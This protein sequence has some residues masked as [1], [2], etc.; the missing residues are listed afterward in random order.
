[1]IPVAPV[2]EPSLWNLKGEEK[3]RAWLAQRPS[4]DRPR[5]REFRPRNYWSAFLGDLGDG[6]Q[7]RCGYTTTYVE[8][9]TV[10]H[11]VA[12]EDLEGTAGEWRAYDWSNV[13][14]AAGWFNSARKRVPVP[15][16]YEVQA[17]WFRL[18]L[19]SL[20]LEATDRVPAG[21]QARV[22]NALQWLKDD[23]R[24]MRGRRKWFAMYN[25]GKI[26]LDGLDEVAPMI[27]DALRRQPEYQIKPKT[28][29]KS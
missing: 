3:G 18:I 25:A 12:W 27:A 14:Y 10:D 6:F 13:R 21:Q 20:Q 9:G 26:G 23:L 2:P 1:M 17:D 8:N 22:D 19:P 29:R 4:A 15:D 16:P 7:W 11:F 28:R 5:D 24:V